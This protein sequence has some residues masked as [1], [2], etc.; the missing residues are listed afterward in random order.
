MTAEN[1]PA[2][3]AMTI[4]ATVPGEEHQALYLIRH[5]DR[6][7]YA[8]PEWKA[9]A[10]R[11]GDPPLSTLGH[12]QA[13]ETGIFL[14][15]LLA[16][17]GITT[18]ERITWLSSPFLRTLQTSDDAINAFTMVNLE[19]LVMHPEYSVFETD[20]HHDGMLHRDLPTME[21]RKCYF[22]RL[23]E[24]YES[25]FVPTLPEPFPAEFM[26]RCDRTIACIHKRFPY[27]PRTAIVVVTHAAVCIGL[28]RAAVANATL[29]DI[30][31]AGPCSVTKLT[32]TSD[33]PSWNLDHYAKEGGMNGHVAHLKTL[34]K[35]YTYPW[36]N[37]GDKK[38]N[39]GYTGPPRDDEARTEL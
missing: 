20:G 19:G 5:G 15:S 35:G 21:E 38:V 2:A 29:Q 17:D 16:K 31:A 18:S 28:A 6:W 33:T 22:P 10:K 14:D 4:T 39:N 36:N 23:N 9:S 34:G 11:P 12:V 27:S 8:N 13:R 24:T 3:A 7:D 26:S 32:R 37:F 30:N 1:G 25:M